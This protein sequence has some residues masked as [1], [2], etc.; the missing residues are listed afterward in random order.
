MSHKTKVKLWLEDGTKLGEDEVEELDNGDVLV[1]CSIN[2]VT[3]TIAIGGG[4]GLSQALGP[5]E[6]TLVGVVV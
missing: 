4:V 5:D 1:H 6:Y 3:H 2:N